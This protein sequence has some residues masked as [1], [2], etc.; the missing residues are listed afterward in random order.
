MEGNPNRECEACGA[1]VA[2][3]ARRGEKEKKGGIE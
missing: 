3:M 2:C 1:Q